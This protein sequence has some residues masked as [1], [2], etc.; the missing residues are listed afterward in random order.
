MSR[1]R[2]Q[3]L[4]TGCVLTAVLTAAG[5]FV[6]GQGINPHVWLIA[7]ALAFLGFLALLDP[8]VRRRHNAALSTDEHLDA[9]C[10]ALAVA[11]RRSG[12]RRCVPAASPTRT[13]SICTGLPLSWT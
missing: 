1:F 5:L 4:L 11:C 9:A 13:C 10:R 6:T 7:L 12:T 8:W 2:Q 3:A